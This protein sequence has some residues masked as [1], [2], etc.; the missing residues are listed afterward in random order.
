HCDIADCETGCGT[1]DTQRQNDVRMALAGESGSIG[2]MKR[3]VVLTIERV[4]L[5]AASPAR[6][7]GHAVRVDGEFR[8]PK[9][10][11]AW[12]TQDRFAA[13]GIVA[14]GFPIEVVVERFARAR[15]GHG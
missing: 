6:A 11:A 13:A 10:G 3:R 4:E 15:D 2:E 7:R 8:A 5:R 9:D 1:E 14:T 12:E